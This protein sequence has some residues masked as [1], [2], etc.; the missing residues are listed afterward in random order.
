[1]RNGPC[2]GT[3]NGECEVVVKPCIW[4]A[5]F[6]RA[7]SAGRLEDL[8]VYIP[9]PTRALKGTSSWVNFFLGRDS[10]PGNVPL[11]AVAVDSNA[12]LKTSGAEATSSATTRIS[13]T[14]SEVPIGKID[15][16]RN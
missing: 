14:D 15:A 5:V 13:Q 4:T 11:Q 6:E 9:P 8:K 3:K 7:K 16:H 2:G 10:R 1:M 12:Q